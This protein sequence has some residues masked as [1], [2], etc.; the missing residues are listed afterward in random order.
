MFYK[1][2]D[3]GENT[4]IKNSKDFPC[5]HII[6]R[7]NKTIAIVYHNNTWVI[8]YNNVPGPEGKGGIIELLDF[9][10]KYKCHGIKK[11]DSEIIPIKE[12]DLTNWQKFVS[13]K[14]K[15]F[16]IKFRKVLLT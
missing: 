2:Y 14:I 5:R 11:L 12:K 9:M 7:Q 1:N 13:F 15:N 10:V 6:I 8:W 4:H 16:A 3:L